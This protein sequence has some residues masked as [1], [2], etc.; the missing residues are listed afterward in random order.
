MIYARV[1]RLC[2]EFVC[3]FVHNDI[4]HIVFSAEHS[5]FVKMYSKFVRNI[6]QSPEI[7]EKIKKSRWNT[8]RKFPLYVLE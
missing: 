8:D 7:P 1:C 2:T 3:A 5:Y 4:K 6:F